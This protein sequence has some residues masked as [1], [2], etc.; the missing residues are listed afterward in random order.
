MT[1]A[2][3]VTVEMFS[4][5]RIPN[6]TD[7]GHIEYQAKDL[8]CQIPESVVKNYIKSSRVSSL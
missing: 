5:S 6:P 7:K 3:R 1:L 4:E 8:H 2:G